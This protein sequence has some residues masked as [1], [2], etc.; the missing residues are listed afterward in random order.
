[1]KVAILSITVGQGHNAASKAL[2]QYMRAQGHEVSIL[3][4]YK[5]LSPFIGFGV[6]KGY[7][8]MGRFWPKLNETIYQGAEKANGRRDMKSTF[9]WAFAD[10]TKNKMK[11]Y[12]EEQDPDVI[13]APIVMTG[14]ITTV[15]RDTELISPRIKT[16]GIVTDYSLHPYWEYTDMD[17][18]VC[19]NELMIPSMVQRGIPKE[20]IQPFGIPIDQKFA[21][22]MDP[23][24][25]REKNGLDPDKYT[26][27]LSAGGMGFAGLVDAANEID[28]V[29]DIQMVAIAGTNQMLFNKLK[30]LQFH[31]PMHV[32]GFVN[33]MDEYMDAA[34]IIVTKPGGLSTSEAIAKGKP[35]LLSDPM[36]GVEY[37][38]QAFLVNNSLAV[39]SNQ[40]QPF[41][42][43]LRQ[44]RQNPLK[45]E[46]MKRAQRQWGK[47]NS[48]KALG[49]FLETVVPAQRTPADDLEASTADGAEGIVQEV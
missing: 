33:N 22:S 43:V 25:A 40:H 32:R 19:A 13:V 48:A 42:E 8:F 26:V 14:I 39:L 49:D 15:L 21:K 11:T 28:A 20:K 30:G 47:R 2:A 36:P 17:Y 31:N 1:M 24:A 34:D 38:N 23:R 7:V 18:F 41:S 16:V 46:E 3:D 4:T 29:D 10:L 35:L 5:F 27:L 45:I 9:P 44:M 6:D 12:I 37:M